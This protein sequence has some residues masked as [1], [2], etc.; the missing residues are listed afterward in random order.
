MKYNKK[1]IKFLPPGSLHLFTFYVCVYG[2]MGVFGGGGGDCRGKSN[3][4]PVLS[5][6]T[7]LCIFLTDLKIK[8]TNK[9]ETKNTEEELQYKEKFIC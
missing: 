7:G 3:S 9:F 4:S 6:S 1:I 8:M 5:L 2:T